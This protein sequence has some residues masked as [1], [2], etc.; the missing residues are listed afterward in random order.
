[1][2][3]RSICIGTVTRGRPL[4]LEN[5]LSSYA[6]M[7]IPGGVHLRF[8][9]VENN[10]T[11]TLRETM[12]SFRERLPQSSIQYELE[13]RLGI[14]FARNR[15]LDCALEAGDH[16]LTFADDDEVVDPA[17]LI[18]L[19]AERDAS[20]LDIVGSPVRIAPHA[21]DA[22][23][24]QKLIWSGIHGLNKKGEAKATRLRNRKRADQIQIGTGSWMGNLSFFRRTMLRFDNALGLSGGEDGVLWLEAKS[25]GAMTGWTPHAVAYETIPS[26]RLGLVYQYRRS[27][28][29]AIVKFGTKIKKREKGVVPRLA[30]SLAGRVSYLLVCVVTLPFKPGMMLVRGARCVGGITGII[31]ACM[32]HPSHHYRRIAGS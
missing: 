22:S 12:E 25:L 3:K 27:R 6:T 2:V 26:E 8:V 10:D 11:P 23:L 31:Q 20:N 21:P 18:Q 14:A 7:R 1:M 5:L 28:D 13:P 30:G 32:G 4:M 17:W 15:V 29:E 24:W 19:L 9:I 16:L